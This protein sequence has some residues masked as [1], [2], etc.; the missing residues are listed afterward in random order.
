MKEIKLTIENINAFLQKKAEAGNK[1][2]TIAEYRRIMLALR[3]WMLPNITLHRET[4]RQWKAYMQSEKILAVRTI[5]RRLA[6]I[7]QFLDFAGER[8]WQVSC[9]RLKDGEKPVLS[10]EEYIRLLQAARK[11]NDERIYFIMKTI[12]VL[13]ISLRE[14]S[15]VTIG[16]IKKGRG[17]IEKGKTA[18]KIVVPSG[19]QKELLAYCARNG[20][21]EGPIFVA[22]RGGEL[23]RVVVNTAMKQLC[24]SAGVK[25]EKA[26]PS[27]LRGLYERT[28][29]ELQEN[30]SMMLL[31]HYE[32]LLEADDVM[33]AWE[34]CDL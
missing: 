20:I 22:Q 10:R 30:I 28:Q 29:K 12:C 27:C 17:E 14:F 3:K 15:Q 11:M 21:H 2:E 18:R 13:G 34:G 8:N 9:L 16:F 25:P 5:N 7:N 31:R 33:V 1:P 32:K 19:L 23:H 24:Q 6:V 4:L 26:T